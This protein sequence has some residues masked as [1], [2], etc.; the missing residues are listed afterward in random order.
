MVVRCDVLR[1]AVLKRAPLEMLSFLGRSRTWH[2]SRRG[3]R[4]G[5]FG[6][7]AHVRAFFLTFMNRY[8]Q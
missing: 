2:V 1:Q 4:H 3:A 8:L 7:S 6:V 5:R